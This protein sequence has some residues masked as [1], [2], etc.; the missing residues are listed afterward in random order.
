M[1][2]S[3]AAVNPTAKDLAVFD[4][5]DDVTLAQWSNLMNSWGWPDELDD[6]P[7]DQNKPVEE[8][9]PAGRRSTLR[10][11][12]EERVGGRLCSWEWNKNRMTED[13]FDDFWRGVYENDS[14]AKARYEARLH[15]RITEN[16]DNE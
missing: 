8:Y 5:K 13:E 11:Y 4:T 16:E 6:E 15:S 9:D 12:L 10:R 1:N 7:D 3:T 14:K 2:D